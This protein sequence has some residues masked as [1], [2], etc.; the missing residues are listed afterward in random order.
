M[1]QG[2]VGRGGR[3]ESTPANQ[4]PPHLLAI[5]EVNLSLTKNADSAS[6]FSILFR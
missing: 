3:W 6:N 2:L 4:T 5:V 1:R